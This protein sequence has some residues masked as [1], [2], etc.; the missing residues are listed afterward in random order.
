MA[1]TTVLDSKHVIHK[2]HAAPIEARYARGWHCLGLADD[3][4][5]GK[6]HGLSVF[7]TRVVVFQSED[8]QLRVLDGYCPHMG[9]DLGQG[10]IEGDTVVCPFHGWQWGADGVCAAI[11]YSQRIP[12]KARIKA[13]PVMEQN[14]LLFV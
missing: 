13:W 1:D 2:I 10:R 14:R 11:P 9:A 12:P 5:D 4:R 6:P 7:G 3:Y 8:G